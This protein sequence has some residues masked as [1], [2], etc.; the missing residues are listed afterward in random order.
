MGRFN[1]RRATFS[2]GVALDMENYVA[3][4]EGAKE[5]V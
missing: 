5:L 1:G 2:I 4:L 3:A